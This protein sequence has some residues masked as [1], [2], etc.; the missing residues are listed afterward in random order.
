M[1]I[2]TLAFRLL[3]P[4]AGMATLAV[5]QQA[6]APQPA[7]ALFPAGYANYET[8]TNALQSVQKRYPTL[9]RVRSLGKSV[10]GRELWLA[11]LDRPS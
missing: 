2:F 7:P 5:A 3:I 11:S 10:E 9:V 6:P 4:F 8:S 1:P